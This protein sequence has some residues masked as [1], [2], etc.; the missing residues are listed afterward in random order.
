MQF[1]GRGEGSHEGREDFCCFFIFLL[2][3]A[4]F[5][6]FSVLS[7][8]FGVGLDCKMAFAGCIHHRPVSTW[9]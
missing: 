8:L 3:F 6:L 4:C 1:L 9:Q 7:I 5:I 2:T